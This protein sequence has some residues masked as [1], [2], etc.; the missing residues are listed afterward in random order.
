MIVAIS[1]APHGKE[2]YMKLKVNRYFAL[3]DLIFHHELKKCF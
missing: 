2:K 1:G 3:Q